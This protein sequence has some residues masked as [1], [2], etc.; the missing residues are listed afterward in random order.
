MAAP[1][2]FAGRRARRR[3]AAV[4]ALATTFASTQVRASDAD[5][6]EALFRDGRTA[7]MSGDHQ[8]ACAKFAE[9]H[10]LDAAVGTLL[11]LAHCEEQLGRVAS[12][13]THWR[14]A[15]E[16]LPGGDA[17]RALPTTRVA[18]LEPRLP[19]L[20]IR[21][22]AP[23]PEGATITRNGEHVDPS[24]LDVAVA[25]DPGPQRLA[26]IV[27][28]RGEERTTVE[29]GEGQ[30]REVLLELPRAPAPPM[31]SANAAAPSPPARPPTST[32]VPGV[33][34]SDHWMRS[35]GWWTV[36]AGAVGI[37]G[38]LVLGALVLD[39]KATVEARCLPSNACDS[40]GL[41]AARSGNALSVASTIAMVTGGVLVAGGVVLVV[42][43]PRGEQRAVAVRTQWSW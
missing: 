32:A 39:R 8:T 16:Q 25:V 38:S 33:P 23:L 7:M 36:G 18:A 4:V 20:R 37:V 15:L 13:W 21:T 24:T 10:R 1:T 27:P 34:S 2:R 31:A 28:G 6:A 3:W 42:A 29:I 5:R 14:M 22:A 30:S 41:A 40:D 17:R 11:N 43:A 35:A 19:R 12:A 9:S 26:L